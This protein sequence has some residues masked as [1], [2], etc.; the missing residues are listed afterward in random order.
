VVV[1]S[2]KGAYSTLWIGNLSQSYGASPA[3]WNH[4]VLPATRHRSARPTLTLTMEASTRF[5]Y[6]GGME[7]WVDLGVGY[8][9]RCFTCPYKSNVLTVTLMSNRIITAS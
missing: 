5:T 8:I 3:I 9:P 6:S 1:F 2:K 7:G 4:T